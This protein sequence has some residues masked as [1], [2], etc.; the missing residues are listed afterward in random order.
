MPGMTPIGRERELELVRSLLREQR[1][2]LVLLVE[3]EAGIGKTTVWRAAVDEATGLGYR[4]LAC[5]TDQTETTLS[6]TAIRD[7]LGDAFDEVAGD[8]PAPQRLA[9]DVMLLREEPRGPPPD[10]SA[11]AVAFLTTL[12]LLASQAPT[13]VAVDDV[14]WLDSPSAAPLAYAL[15]RL[16]RD[17]VCFLLARRTPS[18]GVLGLEKLASGRLEQVELTGLTLGA[19]GRVIHDR[20]G[21]T[22]PRP[23]LRRLYDVSAGNPLYALELARALPETLA[24]LPPWAP[25]PVPQTLRAL[26][27][28]RLAALPSASLEALSYAAALSRPTVSAI[29]LAV[30]GDARRL[31]AL[32]AEA[33]LIELRNDDL[34]FRHPLYAAAVYDLATPPERRELHRRLAAVVEDVEQRGR[35]LAFAADGPDE[36]VADA[37]EE[38]ARRTHLRG[39]RIA[40]AELFESAARLTPSSDEHGR[41][42]RTLAAAASVYEAGDTDHAQA[43]LRPLVSGAPDREQRTEAAW[44]LGLILAD[45]SQYEEAQGLWAEA[46]RNSGEQ[47]QIAELRRGMAVMAMY[48]GETRRAVAHATAAV[49][50]ADASED[51]EQQAYALSTRAW[52]GLLAGE[53]GHRSLLARAVDLEARLEAPWSMWSPSTMVAECARFAL[54]LDEARAAYPRIAQVAVELGN[55]ELEWWATFGLARTELLAGEIRAA[56]PYVESTVALAEAL[57]RLELPTRTLRAELDG[58]LGAPTD[59]IARLEQVA[60]E[61]ARLGEV[62]WQR[63]ALAALG[64]IALAAADAAVAADAFAEASRLAAWVGMRHPSLVLSLADEVEAAVEAGRVDQADAALAARDEL[65]AAPAWV[66][67]VLLRAKAAR[68]AAAGDGQ[69]AAAAL[70]VAVTQP[71]SG[72]SAFHRARSL[73]LLGR[74]ERRLRHRKASRGHLE[75][76][77]ALFVESGAVA[78][79]EQARRDLD[80]IGGRRPSSDGLTPAEQRVAG[81]V[82]EGKSNKE[83]AAVLVVSVHTVEAALTSIYRKLEIRSRTELTRKLLT[84]SKD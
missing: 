44:R 36:A 10:R 45:T 51:L 30:G 49:V 8:L 54:D 61:A 57:G 56:A 29:T 24:P 5:S 63:Q 3:G 7:L 70:E 33:G 69:G 26:V 28:E 64:R 6:Y 27:E 39:A 55:V 37:V 19:L 22:H 62:R 46:V 4:V 77:V 71:G 52:A 23:T 78:W 50:A 82:A 79:A 34:R 58:E 17:C 15:R 42:R 32:P 14:Q 84:E 53:S 83:V 65:G 40:C 20:L 25:L 41:A 68:L 75:E 13:L 11:V 67:P 12:R 38:A 47:R 60:A 72:V 1:E 9:L 35:H 59:A 18:T 76:S 21:V 31:L 48:A 2:G 80:R 43:L 16:D 74:T 81:L 66:E 73:L